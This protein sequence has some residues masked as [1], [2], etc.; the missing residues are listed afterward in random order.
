MVGM[1]PKEQVHL[2]DQGTSLL[3]QAEQQPCQQ[4]GLLL[5]GFDDRRGGFGLWGLQARETTRDTCPVGVAMLAGE[6]LELLPGQL[7]GGLG[8]GI[9]LDEVQSRRAMNVAE[10]L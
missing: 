6:E 8:C 5:I 1:A 2:A 9:G 4:D 10:G 7:S 3:N